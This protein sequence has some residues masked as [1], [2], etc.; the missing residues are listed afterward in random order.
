MRFR[1]TPFLA[2]AVVVGT[3]LYS[4]PPAFASAPVDPTADALAALTESASVGSVQSVLSDLVEE[5]F[6]NG[7]SSGLHASIAGSEISLPT[8]SLRPVRLASAGHVIEVTLPAATTAARPHVTGRGIVV[9]DNAGFS[10]VPLVKTDASIQFTTVIHDASAPL[11]YSYSFGNASLELQPDGLVTVRDARGELEGIIGAAWA[12][13]GA[14]R[15]VATHYVI[16]G[17]ILTQVVE[18][19]GA[20]YP[21]VADPYLGLAQIDSIRNAYRDPRGVTKVVTP[22]AWGRL[23]GNNP[24]AVNGMRDEYFSK[25]SSPYRTNGMWWQLGCHMQFA[26]LK[27]EWNLDSYIVRGSY[28]DYVAHGCN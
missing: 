19:A 2:V 3:A 13:D 14:Q 15:T 22:T 5:P 1:V 6:D 18:H 10:T 28:A 16:D 4:A 23:N 24:T 9:Y 21:V 8:D 7:Q 25:V 20:Q 27:S 26:P 17:P 12:T 11:S